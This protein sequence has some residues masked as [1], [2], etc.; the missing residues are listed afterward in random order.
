MTKEEKVSQIR[1]QLE[2]DFLSRGEHFVYSREEGRLRWEKNL[3]NE[4][5][6]S[7]ISSSETKEE[8]L[9]QAYSVAR[10]MITAMAP[11][12]PVKVSV[13]GDEG[14]YTDGKVLN[15][16]TAHFDD[17]DISLAEKMDAF[18]GLTVHEGC[19]LLYTDFDS[20]GSNPV[21]HNI[22]NII[23]DERI[24]RICGEQTP[25]LSGFLRVS[26]DIFYNR[27]KKK[28]PAEG[29]SNVAK[30]LN[31]LISLVRYPTA[32]TDEEL[33]EF[34]DL[35]IEAKGLLQPFPQSTQESVATAD[36]LYELLK[37]H[38]KQQEQQK[39]QGQSSQG[40]SQEQEQKNQQEQS[41][42]GGSE[43]QEQQ[44]Q[45]AGKGQQQSQPES[46]PGEDDEDLVRK[47]M[48]AIDEL[49]L[50][51]LSPGQKET[52][53]EDDQA[54]VVKA[55]KLMTDLLSGDTEKAER[56][57]GLVLKAKRTEW[58]TEQYNKDYA[59]IR[60]FV[61]AISRILRCQGT[62]EKYALKGQRNGK[63]DSSKIAE[64]VQGVQTVYTK[65]AQ[66][67]GDD[68]A[69]CILIDESGSMCGGNR[70]KAARKAAIL[71]EKG[72]SCV[73]GID[74]YIYGHTADDDGNAGGCSITVYRERG[75]A[76]KCA[77]GACAA[78]DNN[79][80]GYAIWEVAN[81]V[82][83]HTQNKCL[84]FVISDGLPNAYI[85]RNDEEGICHT[86][87]MVQ[88]VTK[89]GFVPVQVAID[90]HYE[91]ESMFDNFV[92][93]NAIE[94]LPRGLSKLVKRGILSHSKRKTTIL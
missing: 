37:K 19:H 54:G 62:C 9:K 25:G 81:R 94:D 72:L 4:A 24:E 78:K 60:A 49:S 1:E 17:N 93:V 23:E 10:E 75:F 69:V 71:L 3:N 27:W 92:V 82:R 14:S 20:T 21:A 40:G 85:Y 34:G 2:K 76:P 31:A 39:Q 50:S 61:P 51:T 88:K 58:T 15:V 13:N 18:V 36:K 7:Y 28:H 90:A 42:Q 80:D 8:A 16:S 77:L 48:E 41:S 43:Q 84:F 86:R 47:L 83:K 12:V 44:E 87:E 53:N 79:A 35:L 22:A 66:V 74:L 73:P 38:L 56:C 11:P 68:L 65:T 67:K 91:P 52:L 6:S 70:I 26:K 45:E 59:D 63:F 29:L 33:D 57:K 30:A 5:L 32:L 55:N 46:A 64:A 89:V